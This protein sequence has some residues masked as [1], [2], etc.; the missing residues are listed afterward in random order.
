MKIPHYLNLLLFTEDLQVTL[1][2]DP[3][4]VLDTAGVNIV[5]W[6][7]TVNLHSRDLELPVTITNPDGVSYNDVTMNGEGL[8]EAILNDATVANNGEYS[9]TATPQGMTSVTGTY[10][11]DVL[12]ECNNIIK[13][14]LLLVHCRSR[15]NHPLNSCLP[16]PFEK[17]WSTRL[18]DSFHKYSRSFF[19]NNVELWNSLD[20]MI[21]DVSDN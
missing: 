15:T 20:N 12:G 16:M 13:L 19:P 14:D 4:P 2:T 6:K 5:T 10:N 3:N 17:V 8:Y 9:C 21:F 1:E 11:L 18:T 7:C